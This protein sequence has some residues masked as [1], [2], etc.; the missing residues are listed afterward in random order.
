MVHIT[1]ARRFGKRMVMVMFR[2]SAV[3][4][5]TTRLTENQTAGLMCPMSYLD[6]WSSTLILFIVLLLAVSGC[7]TDPLTHR[8]R[9]MLFTQSKEA[10]MG[11]KAFRDLLNDPKNAVIADGPRQQ[12]VSQIF[13]RLVDAAKSSAHGEYAKELEWE[14][15]LIEDRRRAGCT[16]FPGGKIAVYTELLSFIEADGELAGAI[17]HCIA[18]IVARHGGEKMSRSILSQIA[19]L[20]SVGAARSRPS[21]DPEKAEMMEA[22]ADRIGLLLA[23]DA[24]YDPDET[25]R[26]W[27]K[28]D[29]P[30]SARKKSIEEFLPEARERYHSRTQNTDSTTDVSGK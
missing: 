6:S 13:A 12:R 18:R 1:S 4:I 9:P 5:P 19:L 24:G 30:L 15:V 14:I 28:L 10:E 21:D 25:L 7:S 29:G 22:E 8:S 20:G 2:R 17:G 26:L 16:S 11:S 3:Q 27:V 23:T